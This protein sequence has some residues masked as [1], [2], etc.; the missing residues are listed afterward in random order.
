[1]LFHDH[2][3]HAARH[4]GDMR[5]AA[6]LQRQAFGRVAR[7]HAGRIEAL[8]QGQGR[9][10]LVGVDLQLLGQAC[11]DVVERLFQIAIVVER[12]DDQLD[13]RAVAQFQHRHAHLLHQVLAQGAVMGLEL[14]TRILVVG[15]LAAARFAPVTVGAVHGGRG[16]A[17]VA[18]KRL[19]FG[20]RRRRVLAGRLGRR[21]G[22]RRGGTERPVGQ[23]AQRTVERIVEPFEQG[24]VR[25][26]LLEF[27]VQFQGRQLQQAYRLLQLRR[28]CQVLRGAQLQ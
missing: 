17:A 28:Q 26:Q 27:L 21:F 20:R 9:A 25:Q 19:R 13:E 10:Q 16:I 3:G 5:Q 14:R 24:I 1:M 11:Q 15:R 2:E 7:A 22:R 8:Q 18:V 4:H 12:I 23:Q 6:D